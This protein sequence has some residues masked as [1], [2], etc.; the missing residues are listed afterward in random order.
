M[1]WRLFCY[2][3]WL[4]AFLLAIFAMMYEIVVWR[5]WGWPVFF[6]ILSLHNWK[7]FDFYGLLIAEEI[8]KQIFEQEKKCVI[9]SEK[10]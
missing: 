10:S 5:W 1:K 3:F 6:L 8:D 9:V 4:L 2:Y 7:N